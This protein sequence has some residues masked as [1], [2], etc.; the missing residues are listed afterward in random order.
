ML[1]VGLPGRGLTARRRYRASSASIPFLSLPA[2]SA[3][4]PRLEDPRLS[5]ELAGGVRGLGPAPE[6][7]QR[8]LGV[9]G[10]LRRL[11]KGL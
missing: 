10:D 1:D 7:G 5:E 11:G 2:G 3:L 8:R 4:V 6:P 9:H